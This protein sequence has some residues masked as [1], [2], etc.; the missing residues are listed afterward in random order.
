MNNGC[1]KLTGFLLH[2]TQG[3]LAGLS[4]RSAVAQMPVEVAAL[5]PLMVVPD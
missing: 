5:K 4:Q 1:L 3:T 2:A